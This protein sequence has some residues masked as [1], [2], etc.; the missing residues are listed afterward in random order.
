MRA[1]TPNPLSVTVEDTSNSNK[2]SCKAPVAWPVGTIRGRPIAERAN[3]VVWLG[4]RDEGRVVQV[5]VLDPEASALERERFSDGARRLLSLGELP[6][7]TRIAEVDPAGR[8]Y[9]RSD[10]PS[11][12][13]CDVDVFDWTLGERLQ[14][15]IAMLE[16]LQGVHQRGLVHG[17]LCIQN[18][19]VT[20][21]HQPILTEIGIVDVA[22]LA[23]RDGTRI[24]DYRRYAAPEVCGG[25]SF[26]H[27]ADVYAAG[28]ILEY[29]VAGRLLSPRER[30]VIAFGAHAEFAEWIAVVVSKAT[31]EE[32]SARYGTAREMML[33]VYRIVDRERR[34]ASSSPWTP[35]G[36]SMED[37]QR[38][39]RLVNQVSKPFG[40]ETPD[41]SS[42]TES[43][44]ARPDDGRSGEQP[45]EAEALHRRPRSSGTLALRLVLLTGIVLLAVML[46]WLQ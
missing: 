40:P 17:S 8:W 31:A 11:K 41:G 15:F 25:D 29:L 28:K 44:G 1:P 19:M 33:A 12:A 27:T 9:V 37:S 43:I 18:I 26:D 32:R 4:S 16:T 21:E 10:E 35:T 5:V 46:L 34:R 38:A 24:D 2:P 7:V 45:S 42:R 14:F 22:L 20:G 3:S 36:Q 39:E 23:G 30:K 13:L 6:H